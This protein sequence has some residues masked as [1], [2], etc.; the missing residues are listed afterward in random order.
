MRLR[1]LVV[2]GLCAG[3]WAPSVGAQSAPSEEDRITCAGVYDAL[4]QEKALG[5]AA[6]EVAT[7]QK[8]FAE[9]NFEAR[10]K[11]AS[12]GL[13]VFAGTKSTEVAIYVINQ[14]R[15]LRKARDAGQPPA[16]GQRMEAF[17]IIIQARQC[18]EKFG[19][20]PALAGKD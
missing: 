5:A 7:R 1:A 10:H 11:A 14:F 20:K 19:F 13:N 4:A 6:F 2:A 9:I 18:D 3:L 17:K 8:N 16:A 15:E 12:Q